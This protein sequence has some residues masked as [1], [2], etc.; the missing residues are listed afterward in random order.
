M[1]IGRC[2]LI[3]GRPCS[4]F[5][6]SLIAV[7]FM[8]KQDTKEMKYITNF[9]SCVSELGYNGLKNC[10]E[11]YE[12]IFQAKYEIDH[13]GYARYDAYAKT[14]KIEICETKS[15][16]NES[17]YSEQTLK[18][19]DSTQSELVGELEANYVEQIRVDYKKK[20]CLEKAITKSARNLLVYFMGTFLFIDVEKS[21]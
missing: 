10:I 6:V 4:S 21:N 15:Q 7:V 3:R 8:Y 20:E 19:M 1:I 17:L 14:L 9:P 18:R 5:L 12:F 11:E 16:L 2:K 13:R